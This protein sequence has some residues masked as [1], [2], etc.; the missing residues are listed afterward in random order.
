MNK[1]LYFKKIGL[2]VGVV[3]ILCSCESAEQK[4]YRLALEEEKR[5]ER[6]IEATKREEELRVQLEEQE[7]KRLEKEERIR[8]ETEEY[9][10]QEK[11]RVE[12]YNRYLNNSLHTG[13][14]PYRKY[15]G[16][17]DLCNI[18]RC[19]EISIRTPSTSDVL[20]I[21]KSKGNVVRHAYIKKSSKYSFSVSNGEYQVFFYY[22][23]GWNPQKKM[24]NGEVLGGFVVEEIFSKDYPQYLTNNILEYELILQQNGNFSTKASSENEIF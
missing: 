15:Y 1:V 2:L 19:S 14:T 18:S 21:I 11:L 22:G 20:V 5:I 6:E 8:L 24:G 23:K 17:N 9:N 4:A 7:K 13:D 16:G 10:R 3:I 12:E